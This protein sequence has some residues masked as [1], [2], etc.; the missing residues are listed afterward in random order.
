MDYEDW[1]LDGLLFGW[2][3]LHLPVAVCFG[4]KYTPTGWSFVEMCP[5]PLSCAS[6]EVV[7]C[8]KDAYMSPVLFSLFSGLN[9]V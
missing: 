3:L 7:L 2:G 5:G 9:Q 6:N 1:V 4:D 8:Y